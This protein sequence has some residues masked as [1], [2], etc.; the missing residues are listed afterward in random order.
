MY[1]SKSCFQNIIFNFKAV[2]KCSIS[3]QSGA[4]RAAAA[5]TH[6]VYDYNTNK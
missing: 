2:Y 1:I 5:V 4:A 6:Y 3:V